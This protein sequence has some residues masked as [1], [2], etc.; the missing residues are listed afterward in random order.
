MSTPKRQQ[1]A[2]FRKPQHVLVGVEEDGFNVIRLG[3]EYGEG[4]YKIL[5]FVNGRLEAE[6]SQ[7][8]DAR[9]GVPKKT[10][11]LPDSALP[12]VAE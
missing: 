7:T 10:D 12:K 5:R 6:Y 2:V 9:L 11:A 3:E 8:V 4:A 1:Y